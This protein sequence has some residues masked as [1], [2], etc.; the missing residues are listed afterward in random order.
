M[1]NTNNV[2]SIE[3]LKNSEKIQLKKEHQKALNGVFILLNQS[4]PL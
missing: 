2:L 3:T 1:A 4:T